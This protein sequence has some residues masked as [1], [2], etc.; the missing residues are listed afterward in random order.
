MIRTA[1]RL[2]T[3][4]TLTGVEGSRPTM[5]GARV[6]DS[7]ID[8]ID[9]ITLP[10]GQVPGEGAP[11]IVVRTE[12]DRGEPL[13]TQGGAAF[14]REVSLVI[15]VGM[16][17]RLPIA[18]DNGQASYVADWPETDA[19]LEAS[20]DLLEYQIRIALQRAH[21]VYGEQWRKL[22]RKVSV[23]E[24]HRQAQDDTGVKF[25]LRETTFTCETRDEAPAPVYRVDPLTGEAID[26]LPVGLERLPE[27]LRSLA[28][29]FP[30]GSSARI[31][32][33]RLADASPI[34]TTAPLRG[35]DVT[36]TPNAGEPEEATVLAVYNLEL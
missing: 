26:T 19:E 36:A 3:I 18:D 24:S 10:D 31:I 5:A 23:I 30:A 9:P 14:L 25:A 28:L 20:L 21:T 4:A 7:R 22:T 8:P 6:Y 27:P 32:S 34:L 11:V 16:I 12:N 1:L 33:E 35:I 17:A 2:L 29:L 15:E 13:N